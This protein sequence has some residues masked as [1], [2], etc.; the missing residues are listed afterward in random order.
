MTA[1]VRGAGEFYGQSNLGDV[2]DAVL[3]T[4]EVRIDRFVV[5]SVECVI[6][7]MGHDLDYFDA[8]DPQRIANEVGRLRPLRLQRHSNP[9]A[10]F[11]PLPYPGEGVPAG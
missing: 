8:P 3:T 5:P 4:G 1:L 6:E 11:A 7:V 2:H 10:C 9:P